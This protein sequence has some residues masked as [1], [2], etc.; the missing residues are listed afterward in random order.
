MSGPEYYTQLLF[1]AIR[2][3]QN[4]YNRLYFAKPASKILAVVACSAI[5]TYV[6][7]VS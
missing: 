6:T 4:G 2:F 5:L 3:D 1:T 7:L